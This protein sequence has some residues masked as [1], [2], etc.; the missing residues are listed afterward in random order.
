M[1]PIQP[2]PA[3]LPSGS[4]GRRRHRG[5]ARGFRWA[6]VLA[7]PHRL[8][9]LAGAGL[10]A[11]AALWWALVLLARHVGVALDWRVPPGSAHA[12]VMSFGFMPVFVSGFAFTAGPR[13]L[14]LGEVPAQRL[15]L[16]LGLQLLGWPLALLGFH[17]SPVLA[18][19]G[20][21]LGAV[22]QGLAT[23]MFGL[24][25][26]ESG[27]RQRQHARWIVAGSAITALAQWAA[28]VL[29]VLGL[30][31][32]V[33]AA[34]SLGL[35]AGVGLVFVAVLHRMVPFFTQAVVPEVAPWR[36]GPLLSILA[37]VMLLQAPLAAAEVLGGGV[38]APPWAMARSV[39][40]LSA[41]GLLLM[42]SWRWGL[43]QSLRV[44]L[45]AMLHIGL[46]WLGL[47]LVLGGLS[48]AWMAASGGAQ[49]LGLAPLHA[50]TMGF[51]GST[52]LAM[53]TRVA[54]GHS[55]RPLRADDW[56][57]ALFWVL[58]VAV[59][60]RVGSALWP[61]MATPLLLLAAQFW[62]AAMAAWVVRHGAWFGRP[63]VDGG[64][65]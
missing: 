56:T 11:L 58:Q 65:G 12:L 7:A 16:P 22:G 23:G 35:W 30:D 61:S 13:W 49:S 3:G 6:T 5:V 38:L 36:P 40:E 47:A 32:G 53:A 29:L 18:G 42:L 8:A 46:A 62:L 48:H 52:L 43:R 9:F 15:V 19:V 41:G 28:A 60:A 55:G 51:L 50:F 44:R 54:R 1:I 17:A 33:R 59:L 20:V 24:M 2:Q 45:L 64:A 4:F 34:A 37:A 39:L 21:A 27:Q 31:A 10:M 25:V 57:W 14:G 26:L 63:R